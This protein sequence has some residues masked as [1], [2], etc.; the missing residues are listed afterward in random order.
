MRTSVS[1]GADFAFAHRA[2]CA[3]AIRRRAASETVRL[4]DTALRPVLPSSDSRAAIALEMRSLSPRSSASTV[5]IV[6]GRNST[7]DQRATIAFGITESDWVSHSKRNDGH[8]IG[9]RLVQELR[10]AR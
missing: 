7:T 9:I 2:L 1:F 10:A 5:C 6:M 3:R 8:P 4:P